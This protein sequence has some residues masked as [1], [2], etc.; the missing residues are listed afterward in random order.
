MDI[1]YKL[2]DGSIGMLDFDQFQHHIILCLGQTQDGSLCGVDG[3]P[4][5]SFG[6][7]L[8]LF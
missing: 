2:L 5:I 6:G 8:V 3:M 7:T 4:S 1:V